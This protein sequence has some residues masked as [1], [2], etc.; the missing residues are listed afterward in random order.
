[1][2]WEWVAPTVTGFVAITTIGVT[3]RLEAVRRRREDHLRAQADA[4][5]ER[6]HQ[7]ELAVEAARM[8]DIVDAVVREFGMARTRVQRK[9]QDSSLRGQSP[10]CFE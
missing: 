4:E 5:K 3:T 7:R 9:S 10:T 1:M 2:S 6:D 8:L